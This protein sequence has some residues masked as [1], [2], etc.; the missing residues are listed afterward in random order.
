MSGNDCGSDTNCSDREVD[1]SGRYNERN[2]EREDGIRSQTLSHA[3]DVVP[4]KEVRVQKIE[5]ENKHEQCEQD[6]HVL[7]S[8]GRKGLADLYSRSAQSARCGKFYF[9][10]FHLYDL[11]NCWW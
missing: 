11:P 9:A 6:D 2:T 4:V 1:A 7:Q 5:D 10:V 3:D 8:L